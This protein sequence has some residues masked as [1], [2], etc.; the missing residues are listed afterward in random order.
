[1]STFEFIIGM[2]LA[3]II[4]L[5]FG[6]GLGKK[7]YDSRWGSRIGIAMSVTSL[8]LIVYG[9]YHW[10]AWP[11]LTSVLLLCWQIAAYSMADITHS[12]QGAREPG[13]VDH[14]RAPPRETLAE[15]AHERGQQAESAEETMRRTYR[16]ALQ[17]YNNN[18]VRVAE[19][20]VKS[21]L[22]LARR[23][24]MLD[25]P[26]AAEL[27]NL[28]GCIH[29]SRGDLRRAMR[30]YESAASVISKWTYLNPTEKVVNDAEIINNNL[31]Q[32]RDQ[33]GF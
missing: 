23:T 19:G 9:A 1:M 29:Q 5:M 22:E 11:I 20:Q 6:A 21:G 10:I 32:C 24:K 14:L 27:Y 30:F 17:N 28:Y 12:R 15:L 7:I 13:R 8:W 33:L 26:V 31:R 25:M 3:A 4:G 16:L 2:A 18:M